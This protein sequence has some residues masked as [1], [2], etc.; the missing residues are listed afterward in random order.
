MANNHRTIGNVLRGVWNRICL[1]LAR[2]LPLHLQTVAVQDR[3]IG[4][5]KVAE[6]KK[7]ILFGQEYATL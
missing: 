6:E 7:M 4:E 5:G 1:V 3:N 2:P